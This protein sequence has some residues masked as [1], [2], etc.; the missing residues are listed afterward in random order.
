MWLHYS[1]T[2]YQT[3]KFVNERIPQI[4]TMDVPILCPVVMRT[5]ARI[6]DTTTLW[7]EGE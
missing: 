5:T 2:I 4:E 1:I 7:K 3:V 6:L